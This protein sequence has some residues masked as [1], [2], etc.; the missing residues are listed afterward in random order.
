[1]ETAGIENN[2][3]IGTRV[4]TKAESDEEPEED[5]IDHA[6]QMEALEKVF[7]QL[8]SGEASQELTN[9][10]QELS[11]EWK[12]VVD[13]LAPPPL[14]QVRRVVDS[15]SPPSLEEV[16]RRFTVGE[17]SNQTLTK[18]LVRK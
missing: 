6:T 14:E 18:S 15:F 5:A 16:F 8:A 2:I 7:D 4:K 11:E 3:E 17:D 9:L 10:G 13:C 1:M 12:R